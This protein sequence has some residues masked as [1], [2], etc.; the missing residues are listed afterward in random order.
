[1]TEAMPQPTTRSYYGHPVLKPPVWKW[2]V[3]AYFFTGGVA[4]GT[5]LLAAGARLTGDRTLARRCRFAAMGATALSTAFLVEDLG[6]PARFL[7]MLRVAKP[8]SPMSVGSWVLSA[9]GGATTVATAAQLVTLPTPVTFLA[10]S[11]ATGL[12]PVLGTYTAVLLADTAVPAWHDAYRELPFVFA[13]GALASSGALGYLMT[14]RPA[15]RRL[16]LTGAAA[17]LGASALMEKRLGLGHQAERSQLAKVATALTVAGVTLVAAPGRRRPNGRSG[18]SERRAVP[19][20]GAV[21]LIAGAAAERFAIFRAG[22]DSARD[23][24]RTIDPQR[25]RLD[26]ADLHA[27]SVRAA[28]D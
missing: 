28:P 27:P 21:L 16:A 4:A 25:A 9:F 22:V 15:A 23:P 2:P 26:Q 3:P 8:T 17:E 24:S 18:P 7:N 1:M 20:L 12:A 10:E 19:A 11:V 5:T 13:G 14:G 6:R